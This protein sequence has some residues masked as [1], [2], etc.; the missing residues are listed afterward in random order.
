MRVDNNQEKILF[1]GGSSL[2]AYLWANAR[3]DKNKILLIE[4]ERQITNSRWPVEKLNLNDS[5]RLA[6]FLNEQQVD[7]VINT[8][9]LTS[10]EK[11]EKEQDLAILVNSKLPVAV[12]KACRLARI[13]M[14]HISTDHFYGL[15]HNCFTEEQTP[16]LMNTYASTKYEGEQGVMAEYPS[17]LICRTNFYGQGPNYRASFSDKIIASLR[18]QTPIAL[19]NDV[20]FSPILGSKLAEYAHELSNKKFSG[21]Y[22]ISSDD[23]MSKYDFGL[24]LARHVGLSANPIY[25]SSLIDRKDLVCRPTAMALSNQKASTA[26][27]HSLGRITDHIKLL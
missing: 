26:L 14:I 8:A 22:N 16:I 1:T 5:S 2:L 10:V 13:K 21:I 9:A 6:C 12:A 20:S 11:C 7:I 4:H 25:T 19:F 27:G 15:E 18:T 3:A 23:I 24:E 17:A